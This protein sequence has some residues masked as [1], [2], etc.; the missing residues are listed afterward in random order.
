MNKISRIVSAQS[1]TQ[2]IHIIVLCRQKSLQS[3]GFELADE[4][5]LVVIVM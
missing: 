1:M 3:N 5:R 2:F 4:D